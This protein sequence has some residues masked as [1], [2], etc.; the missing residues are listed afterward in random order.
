MKKIITRI[1]NPVIISSVILCC[2]CSSSEVKNELP[3]ESMITVSETK[4]S[5]ENSDEPQTKSFSESTLEITDYEEIDIS[6]FETQRLTLDAYS[7]NNLFFTYMNDEYLNLYL[8][9]TESKEQKLISEIE[10]NAM[11]CS[12]MIINRRYYVVMP[13]INT[14]NGLLSKLYVYDIES[15][16]FYE[17]DNFYAHNIVQ[18]WTCVNDDK[19]AYIYY[20]SESKDRVVRTYDFS[21]KSY[22]ELYR[23]DG[24]DKYSPMGLTFNGENLVLILQ[25]YNE[26][27][28]TETVF[29]EINLQGNEVTSIGTYDYPLS[30]VRDVF[31]N[32]GYYIT[33]GNRFRAKQDYS[34]VYSFIENNE[35]KT[36]LSTDK[37]LKIPMNFFTD[38]DLS[39]YTCENNCDIASVN[40]TDGEIK[41]YDIVIPDCPYMQCAVSNEQNDIAV[42]KYSDENHT[43]S[44]LALINNDSILE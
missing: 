42:I 36:A 11:Y 3:Q 35:I 21:T 13:S 39:F 43:Q 44:C 41:Y 5:N 6:D 29:K 38:N 22:T 17:A 18:Y 31:F 16:E 37:K 14:D 23:I 34:T 4:T 1:I 30:L 27:Y 24:Q 8:L 2:S 19:L 15:G 32:N 12:P 28:N 40:T 9:N 20:E 10:W 7:G 25:L 26:E 33:Y